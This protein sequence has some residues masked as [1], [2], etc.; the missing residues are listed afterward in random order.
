VELVAPLP[1]FYDREGVVMTGQTTQ[2]DQLGDL[3]RR[4]R[5]RGGDPVY[6]EVVEFLEDE[7]ALLDA[8]DLMGWVRML[9]DDVDYRAPVRVTR[10]KDD[11]SEFAE[12]MFH[13]EESAITIQVKV[14][15]LVNTQ[16]A[17][18]ENPPSR[19]RRFVTNIRVWE[20]DA[21]GEYHTSSSILLV[22]N[23]Y[24]QSHLD[25]LTARREDVIR[26]HTDG[27]KLAKRTIYFDQAS[28]GMQNLA[29]FL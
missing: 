18:A 12:S 6:F 26:A 11:G 9:T 8:N 15:R 2:G 24:D 4:V 23:R 3:T 25:M 21:A 14:M 29:V 22:R 19:T 28:L 27:Y 13:F 20:G 1:R 16:S 7:A 17:W 5:I 10:L